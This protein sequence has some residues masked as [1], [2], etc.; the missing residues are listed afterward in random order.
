MPIIGFDVGAFL[1]SRTGVG[2]CVRELVAALLAEKFHATG[3]VRDMIMNVIS[4]ILG[5]GNGTQI[6]DVAGPYRI[7]ISTSPLETLGGMV[8]YA[9]AENYELVE[10]SQMAKVLSES[11]LALAGL[12]A[13]KA[14]EVGLTITVGSQ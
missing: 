6:V 7:Q 13:S 9:K 1:A 12:S 3:D 11:E 5:I 2:V 8:G 14:V 10:R 4:G